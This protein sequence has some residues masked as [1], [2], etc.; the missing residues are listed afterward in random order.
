MSRTIAFQLYTLRQFEDGWEA[1]FE[2]LKKHGIDTIE[3]WGG[4]VPSGNN[5]AMQ[6][7]EIE[8]ILERQQM[9]LACGHLTPGDFDQR[10]EVC[11]QLL[12]KFG[13]T[14]WVIPFVPA[15]TFEEWLGWLPKFRAMSERLADDGL[16]LGYHN[17][18]MELVYHEGKTVMEHLLDNL[19]ELQAQLHIGQF[20]P[21]R[22]VSLPKLLKRY[23]GRVCALHVNDA[24]SR[25][26]S[27]L[28]KGDCQAELA[29]KTALDTGVDTFII[30]INLTR[31]TRD[32]VSRDIETLKGWL[33]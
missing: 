17:H 18:H 6:F 10:Y 16:Q 3:M 12:K 32:Q 19:P 5:Q 14:T 15:Q 22:N 11:V 20:L 25:G 24:T 4:A 23:E 21:E 28:G 30:E 9:K 13:S 8:E 26:Y 31:E 27:P 7:T 33:S 2:F 1:A 29:V